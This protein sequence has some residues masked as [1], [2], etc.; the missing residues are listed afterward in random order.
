MNVKF[1]YQ[2][3]PILWFVLYHLIC[4]LC[5]ITIL[6]LKFIFEEIIFLTSKNFNINIIKGRYCVIIYVCVFP[7]TLL[8][9]FLF[10]VLQFP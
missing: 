5:Q 1:S 8:V 9:C 4:F 2:Y 10:S 7:S 6:I 3:F